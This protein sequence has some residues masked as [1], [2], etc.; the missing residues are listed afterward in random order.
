L[1]KSF[2]S[3]FF[4]TS[5]MHTFQPCALCTVYTKAYK[6]SIPMARKSVSKRQE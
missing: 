1:Y 2:Y 5:T 4:Q 3:A 6:K